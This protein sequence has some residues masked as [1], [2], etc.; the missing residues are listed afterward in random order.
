MSN[1]PLDLLG[2]LM[3]EIGQVLAEI[4]GGN[5]E[6]VF[7]Y[8]E[9][10]K[11]WVGPSIFKDEGDVV[12]Y[13]NSDS[14]L[15]DLLFDAWYTAPEDKRWSVME[16]DIKDGKFSVAFKYPEEVDVEKSFD[17]ARRDAVLH[18]RYGDK[19]VVYPPPP[20]GMYELKP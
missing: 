2:P 15:T 4:A 19:P 10:G 20:E 6:G 5:P 13:L 9:V 1:D 11:G 18:A 14:D 12:R 17:G 8:A 3:S 7:L 16:Y